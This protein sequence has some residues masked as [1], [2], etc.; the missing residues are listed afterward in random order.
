MGTTQDNE[1]APALS[2]MKFQTKGR[3][4]CSHKGLWGISFN[5]KRNQT[6]AQLYL[7][8]ASVGQLGTRAA[9]WICEW[10]LPALGHQAGLC[11]A[12]ELRSFFLCG[13]P[14]GQVVVPVDKAS[15]SIQLRLGSGALVPILS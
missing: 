11:E 15:G 4:Y 8:W 3:N 1:C 2:T 13:A 12:F 6:P 9:S 7:L 10:I 14:G 5:L